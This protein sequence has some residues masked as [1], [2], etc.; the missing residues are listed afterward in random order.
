MR[1]PELDMKI[2]ERVQD[3]VKFLALI[4]LSSLRRTEVFYFPYLQILDSAKFHPPSINPLLNEYYSASGA[5]KLR[6][7]KMHLAAKC[8]FGVA[9]HHPFFYS[10]TPPPTPLPCYYSTSKHT[11]NTPPLSL[12]VSIALK[13]AHLQHRKLRPNNPVKRNQRTTSTNPK[14]SRTGIADHQNRPQG[15]ICLRET[16]SSWAEAA[17]HRHERPRPPKNPPSS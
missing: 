11:L 15:T 1:S 9:T 16:T 13:P 12:T 5:S 3:R 4:S 2:H 8:S 10:P 17:K 6:I 14:N 7:R